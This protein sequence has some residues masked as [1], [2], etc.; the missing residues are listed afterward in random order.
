MSSVLNK[1]K[2]CEPYKTS[3][4]QCAKTLVIQ[5]NVT[6]EAVTFTF[7]KFNGKKYIYETMTNDDG[8]AYIDLKEFPPALFNSYNG[9]FVVTAHISGYSPSHYILFETDYAYYTS[10][11]LSVDDIN[12]VN[13]QLPEPF[14]IDMVEY[15]CC[16]SKLCGGI[17][18]CEEES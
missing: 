10:L 13:T 5:T 17:N 18:R 3:F 15:V 2:L 14:L 6:N 7:T 8:L 11:L 16:C 12:Y 4:A 9:D 1:P